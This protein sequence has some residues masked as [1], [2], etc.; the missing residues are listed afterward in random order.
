MR[1][2]CSVMVLGL[3]SLLSM[4]AGSC[5]RV[6]PRYCDAETPCP[7][8]GVCLMPQHACS[9]PGGPDL[10][11]QG[12]DLGP[13][14]PD[15][16]PDLSP[17]KC[18]R[19]YQC[20]NSA[21]DPSGACHDPGKILVVDDN[22]AV[23][24]KNGVGG[25]YCY[26]QDAVKDSGIG[27]GSKDLILIHSSSGKG[28]LL[29]GNPIMIQDNL[30]LVGA[31]TART[32]P[33]PVVLE[34]IVIHPNA[35]KNITVGIEDLQVR[36]FPMSGGTVGIFCNRTGADKTVDLTLS[37]SV[38]QNAGE[39]GVYTQFCDSV[40]MISNQ[41]LT[42]VGGGVLVSGPSTRLV[43]WNN[44]IANNGNGAAQSGLAIFDPVGASSSVAFN[45]VV[46]NTCVGPGCNLSCQT[47]SPLP[48]SFSIALPSL[49]GQCAMTNSVVPG[50]YNGDASNV[51]V[52]PSFVSASDYHLAAVPAN[53]ALL[54]QG[55][56]P[57]V[58][59]DI[60]FDPRPGA[61]GVDIGADQLP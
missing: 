49:S 48:V 9:G 34:P 28:H 10:S 57:V 31:R 51:K 8:G 19:N 27:N 24:K 29:D 33:Q 7:M 60:D 44:I 20:L 46:N 13:N 47:V 54:K 14:P 40:R 21:C 50:S 25:P 17:A 32:D 6:D 37:W 11:M 18:Q 16:A 59:Y 38:V 22:M 42:N 2:P 39:L 45:T 3:L 41:I 5:Y 12:T 4:T 26:I 1:A 55:V 15:L 52:M 56:T 58:S 30:R 23:C 35:S 43:L 53:A 36:D 61:G